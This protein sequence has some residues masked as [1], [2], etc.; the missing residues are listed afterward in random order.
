M[1][2]R[3]QKDKYNSII[4]HDMRVLPGENQAENESG[5][6]VIGGLMNN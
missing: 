3:T 1:K 6:V 5:V 2:I 4:S